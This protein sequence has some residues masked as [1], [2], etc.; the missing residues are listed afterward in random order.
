MLDALV[1]TIA[2]TGNDEK[3]IKGL[4]AYLGKL[5]EINDI[6]SSSTFLGSQLFYPRNGF[7]GLLSRNTSFF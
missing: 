7:L 5:F 1:D 6:G 3:E 4:K 2:V